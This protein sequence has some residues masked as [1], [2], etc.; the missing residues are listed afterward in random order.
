MTLVR[1]IAFVCLLAGLLWAGWGFAHGNQDPVRIDLLFA[2][3][4]S[5]A[6]WQALAAAAF[7]GVLVTTL[8]LGFSLLRARLEARRFRKAMLGLETEVHQLR[9]LPLSSETKRP[10]PAGQQG[11]PPATV[12]A[13]RQG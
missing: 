13:G 12:V 10:T 2:R 6:L 3:T 4:G 7:L 5:F 8:V 9:N 11:V 1:R